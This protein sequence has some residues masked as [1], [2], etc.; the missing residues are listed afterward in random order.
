MQLPE[1]IYHETAY[2]HQFIHSRKLPTA[3]GSTI[4]GNGLQTQN[5]SGTFTRTSP[6]YNVPNNDP[7][8]FAVT[9][10]SI[11]QAALPSP[12]NYLQEILGLFT[13]TKLSPRGTADII[14][15]PSA[16]RQL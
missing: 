11:E 4:P 6:R 3:R 1:K 14:G 12:A 9:P 8:T 5:T 2:E 16:D 7:M 13:T 10:A 15:L